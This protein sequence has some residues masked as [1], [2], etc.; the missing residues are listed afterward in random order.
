[1]G[2]FAGTS[3]IIRL[4]AGLEWEGVDHSDCQSEVRAQGSGFK[5]RDSESGVQGDGIRV[6]CLK[7]KGQFSIRV[8]R[9]RSQSR[10]SWTI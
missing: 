8:R 6:L 10:R 1:M 3:F 5:D 9:R 2:L 7:L 4:L